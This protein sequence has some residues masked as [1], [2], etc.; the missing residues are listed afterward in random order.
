M[1]RPRRRRITSRARRMAAGRDGCLWIRTTYGAQSVRGESIA[2]HEGIPGHHLQI[3]IAQELH[4]VPE[5]RKFE[6]Y[7]AYQ[8]GWGLYAER[9]GKDVGFYRIRTRIMGGWRGI[10]GGR[11]GWWWIPACTRSTGRGIRWWTY[12]H[13]HSAIDE[14]RAIQS[15]TDRYIAWPGQALAYKVGQ[16]KILE[17]RERAKTALGTKFDIRAFHDQVLDSGALPLDVL[18]K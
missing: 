14:T 8:E 11:F 2:Y 17:L 4:G 3:S 1:R 7:T 13:D 10:S 12:F 15:E 9:L 5:F 16:L 6:S 18:E